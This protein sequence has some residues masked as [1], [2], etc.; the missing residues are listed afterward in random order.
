MTEIN[1]LDVKNIKK[2][3]HVKL[4]KFYEKLV[5][6]EFCLGLNLTVDIKLEG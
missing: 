2:E 3:F 5:L 1:F 4:S 6:F